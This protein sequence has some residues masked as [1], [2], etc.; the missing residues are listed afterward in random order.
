MIESQIN[1]ILDCLRMMDR[2]N[3]QSIEIRAE[4]EE[5]YNNEMQRRMKGTVWTAGG[6][7]SWYLDAR[8]H[9]TTLWPG[10]TF[11]FRYRTRYFDPQHYI[12]SQRVPAH[13]G[14]SAAV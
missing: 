8:G 3:V 13:V 4:V 10:F 6:C 5:K 12:L 9:N 1:Y 14:A 7:V 2:R 11:E